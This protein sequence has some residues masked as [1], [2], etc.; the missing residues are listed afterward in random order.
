MLR[1]QLR[2]TAVIHNGTT[3]FSCMTL[4]SRAQLPGCGH[5]EGRHLDSPRVEIFP[6]NMTKEQYQDNGCQGGLGSKP[7]IEGREDSRGPNEC[8]KSR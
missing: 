6:R 3:P 8:G 1:V 7:N 2:L 5:V 4:F